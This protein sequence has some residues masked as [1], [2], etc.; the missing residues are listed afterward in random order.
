MTLLICGSTSEP[1]TLLGE[2]IANSGEG[3]VWRTNHNGY[4]AKIYHSP[5]LERVQKL[6]VMIVHSLTYRA[7]F[8]PQ[9][10]FF[11]LA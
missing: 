7:K 8:P 6:A 2:P 3:K 5:T 4:L 1:I 10:Y 11:C 9:S